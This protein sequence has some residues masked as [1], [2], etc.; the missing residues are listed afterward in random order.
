MC[1]GDSRKTDDMTNESKLWR[2][3]KWPEE[4]AKSPLHSYDAERIVRKQGYIYF[5][6]NDVLFQ[7]YSNAMDAAILGESFGPDDNPFNLVLLCLFFENKLEGGNRKHEK[8][9]LSRS[10]MRT[11]S[12]CAEQYNLRLC[13]MYALLG[14]LLN[15]LSASNVDSKTILNKVMEAPYPVFPFLPDGWRAPIIGKYHQITVDIIGDGKLYIDRLKSCC[16]K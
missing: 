1:G 14:T 10:L 2:M 4:W 6:H 8:R 12:D 7:R 16:Y 5:W 13:E 15:P 9:K 3:K 11:L